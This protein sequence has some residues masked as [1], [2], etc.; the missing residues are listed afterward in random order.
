[1][2]LATPC[3]PTGPQH[4]LTGL[5]CRVA[6]PAYQAAAPTYRTAVPIYPSAPLTGLWV[7]TGLP[8]CAADRPACG[9]YRSADL[10]H[11]QT[12]LWCLPACRVGRPAVLTVG[13]PAVLVVR[14]RA[15]SHREALT[16]ILPADE[17]PP[18]QTRRRSAWRRRI[19]A[20]SASRR[21]R[22]RRRMPDAR[23]CS[24]A[25]RWRVRIRSRTSSSCIESMSRPR[26]PKWVIG[27]GPFTNFRTLG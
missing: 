6:V 7:P 25:S 1:M 8:T 9:A 11:R 18:C 19:D 4:R 12:G 23:R 16:H 2:T 3:R 5:R 10:C 22:R 27:G 17:R 14:G 26:S 20:R 13:R 21:A 24:S 15:R